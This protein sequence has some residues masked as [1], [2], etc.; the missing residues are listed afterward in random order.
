MRR[1]LLGLAPLALV[2]AGCGATVV[3]YGRSPDRKR[4]VEVIEAGHRQRVRLDGAAGKPYEGI[5]LAA[6][7]FSPDSHRLAYP[8][9]RKDGSWVVVVDG[10][11]GRPWDGIGELVFSPDGREVVY[12][13][14]RE[15]TWHVV[16]SGRSIA[17]AE[18]VFRGTL[19]FSPGGRR[20]AW[21]ASEGLQARV[22]LDGAEGPE[23]DAVADLTFSPDG[24]RHGYAAREG[25]RWRP[26]VD[27]KAGPA[28]DRV[29]GLVFSRGGRSVAYAARRGEAA[30]VVKDGAEGP[31]H[32]AVRVQSLAFTAGG[33]LLYVARDPGGERVI[34]DGK[35]GPTFAA[36]DGPVLSADGRQWGYIGRKKEQGGRKKEQGGRKKEQGGRK[37]EQGGHKKEQGGRKK[38]Q[39]GRKKEQGGRKKEWHQIVIGGVPGPVHPWADDL[40]LSPDGKRFA[41]LVRRGPRMAVMHAA[42]RRGPRKAVLH[43][44]GRYDFDLVL[45]GSL[46]FSADGRHLGCLAGDRARRKLFIA[47]DG[48]RRRPFDL[49]ELNAAFMVPRRHRR[50]LLRR[51]VA[52]ELAAALA[53]AVMP[54]RSGQ[55][56]ALA[57]PD[58]TLECDDPAQTPPHLQG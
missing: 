35:R 49:E 28:Y 2:C 22:V 25:G 32:E 38:E 19:R 16:R 53:T 47:V 23:H 44:G 41:Y 46:V 10:K 58:P 57:P 39:G 26:Y 11:E 37:K 17:T 51:W 6:V 1:L 55:W 8:A 52:A 3:W 13:A 12:L 15:R 56:N 45:A 24:A 43:P 31:P 30:L 54:R 34:L 4:R 33:E 50:G 14:R 21:V 48:R 20:L 36:V 42:V 5:G 29:A 7:T 40:V 9:R 18:A 27:G